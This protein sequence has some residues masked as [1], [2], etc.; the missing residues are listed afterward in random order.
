MQPLLT[1]SASKVLKVKEATVFF[2][3]RDIR[4]KCF[5]EISSWLTDDWYPCA[6]KLDI[7]ADMSIDKHASSHTTLEHEGVPRC[8]IK[9]CHDCICRFIG[10]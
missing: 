10:N 7:N 6:K 4:L 1:A 8:E 2:S 5:C 3:T 9:S